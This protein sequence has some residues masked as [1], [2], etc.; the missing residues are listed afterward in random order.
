[1]LVAL[2]VGD[3]MPHLVPGIERSRHR[4][5]VNM[6]EGIE[7]R[8]A[9]AG[10]EGQ[11]RLVLGMDNGQMLR[12]LFE[13][14]N[15]RRLIVDEDTA[16]AARSDLAAKDELSVFGVEAV[17]FQQ[18]RDGLR[19]RFEDRRDDGLVGTVPNCV[20]GSL[21][22]QQQGERVNKDGFSGASFAGQQVE[23]GSKLHGNVV[24]DRVVFD[25]QFQQHVSSRLA[26]S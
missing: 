15:G 24:N 23:A 6:G 3:A 22:A 17:G 13:H 25:P 26:R 19:L 21:V 5:A 9:R 8:Q 20:G 18:H 11:H 16:L 2:Q 12:E 4:S 7:Q 10:I 14:S 1:M